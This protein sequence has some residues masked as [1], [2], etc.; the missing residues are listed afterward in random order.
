MKQ[1]STS[2][3]RELERIAFASINRTKKARIMVYKMKAIDSK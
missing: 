2:R 1:D 3:W